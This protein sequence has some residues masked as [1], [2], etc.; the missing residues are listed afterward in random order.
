MDWKVIT[1][2]MGVPIGITMSLFGYLWHRTN[3]LASKESV[4]ALDEK[5]RNAEGCNEM[6]K[7]FTSEIANLGILMKTNFENQTKLEE[8][9]KHFYQEQI[10]GLRESNENVAKRVETMASRK[11]VIGRI[12]S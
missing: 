11:G 3:S 12:F 5:K 9:K 10:K 6:M 4:K 1:A 7:G 8:E 2:V